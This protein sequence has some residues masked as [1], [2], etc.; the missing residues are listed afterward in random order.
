M[1][2]VNK[3]INDAF[4]RRSSDIH[5]ELN[6]GKKNVEVRY[7]VDG[8]CALYQSLPYS[9]RA[10]LVSRIKIMSNLDITIR[11]LPQDGKIKFKRPN[12]EEIE[13][14]VDDPDAG[15]RRG[16]RHSNT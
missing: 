11:R 16:C 10:A 1:Q 5:I 8:D 7:R 6:V 2:L 12:G 13:L 4:N 9:Y 15:R 14:R 3:I